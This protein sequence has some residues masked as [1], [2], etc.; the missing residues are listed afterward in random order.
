[1]K[2]LIRFLLSPKT[3]VLLLTALAIAGVISTVVPQSGTTE[4]VFFAEWQAKNPLWCS[5]VKI[6]RLDQIFTSWWFLLLVGLIACSLA[7]SLYYQAKAVITNREPKPANSSLPHTTVTLASTKTNMRAA[8]KKI[9]AA[10]Q[11]RIISTSIEGNRLIFGKNRLGRWGSV[12]FHLGLL[13][14]IIAALYNSVHRQR[15]FATLV[16]DKPFVANAENWLSTELGLLAPPYNLDLSLQLTNFKPEY[17]QNDQVKTMNS[18]VVINN[19]NGSKTTL[20]ISVNKPARING[21]KLFL[22]GDYGYALDFILNKKSSNPILTH[23]LMDAQTQKTEPLTCEM[24]FPTTD[25]QLNIRFFPDLTKPSHF[26]TFPAVDL[27][28]REKGEPPQSGRLLLNQTSILNNYNTM[29]LNRVSYWSGV[30]F[31]KT[32]GLPLLYTGFALSIAGAFILYTLPFKVA[33]FSIIEEENH[34]KLIISGRV[35]R[36]QA[37]FVHELED[38]AQ[39]LN[40]EV[41]IHGDNATAHS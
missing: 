37:L 20:P 22:S 6:L 3:I 19:K 23:I 35:K 41:G 21:V 14:V 18:E 33:Y 24:N 34:L 5:L 29:T 2:H 10:N 13:C 38:I 15:G 26:P 30:I 4:P 12:I 36:Y 25:Y 27:V 28:I 7:C 17:W 9:L 32:Y 11:Y 40:Q 16:E 1:M 8:I 31:V 39:K